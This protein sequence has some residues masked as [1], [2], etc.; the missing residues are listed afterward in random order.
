MFR[1]SKNIKLVSELLGILL[2]ILACITP[3]TAEVGDILISSA[4]KSLTIGTSWNLKEGYTITFKDID[5]TGENAIIVLTKNNN[6]VIGDILKEGDSFVYEKKI[7]NR[8]YTII[9]FRLGNIRSGSVRL[10]SVYQYSDGSND[11]IST[12][13]FNSFGNI[14]K[15]ISPVNGTVMDNGRT[16][17]QNSIVWDFDWSDVEDA[18]EYQLY[19]KKDTSD[20]PVIN[21]IITSSSY[22]HVNSGS[23]IV[24]RNRFGWIWK[25]RAKVNGQWC[26]W[27]DTYKFNVEEINTD[28]PTSEKKLVPIVTTYSATSITYNSAILQATVNPN[29]LPTQ[30]HFAYYNPNTQSYTATPYQNVGSGTSYKSVSYRLTGLRSGTTN[31]YYVIATNSAGTQSGTVVTFTTPKS[32][33]TPHSTPYNRATPVK[34]SSKGNSFW[35]FLLIIVFLVGAIIIYKIDLKT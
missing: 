5:E 32:A 4:S 33:T 18:S 7:N 26:D 6:K 3:V 24:N 28:P 9:S 25:V 34:Q 19:V 16:D 10:D 15:L 12:A 13:Q 8:K 30:A 20:N 27:S 22:H 23:Y 31:Y 14:V 35:N 29:G 11:P 2:I 1:L 21:K 17:S